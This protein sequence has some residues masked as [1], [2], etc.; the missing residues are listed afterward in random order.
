MFTDDMSRLDM[1]MENTKS[2]TLENGKIEPQGYIEWQATSGLQEN[3]RE[4]MD[5]RK[6]Y[7]KNTFL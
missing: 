2:V 4:G 6:V 7:R 1:S 5:W 3:R